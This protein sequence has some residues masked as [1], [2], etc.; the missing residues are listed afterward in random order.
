M[1]EE[2]E[3]L[4]N[5]LADKFIPKDWDYEDHNR[6]CFEEGWKAA[7]EHPKEE[8]ESYR[9]GYFHGLTQTEKDMAPL[10]HVQKLV[11]ALREI[12][13]FDSCHRLGGIDDCLVCKALVPWDKERSEGK[14]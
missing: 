5:E 13:C 7:D 4:M 2:R 10:S 3:K 8:P 1:T 6:H 9:V 12:G 14:K 11:D